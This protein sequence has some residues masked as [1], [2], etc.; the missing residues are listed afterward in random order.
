MPNYKAMYFH[1]AAR[2]ADAAELLVEAQK[3]GE[4][5]FMRD[6]PPPLSIVRPEGHTDNDKG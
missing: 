4:E 6:D 1:L 5:A 3:A 2:V